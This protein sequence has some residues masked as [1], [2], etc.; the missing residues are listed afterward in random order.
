MP[1]C[2]TV[3]ESM[4]ASRQGIGLHAFQLLA[5]LRSFLKLT[6]RVRNIR[7]ILFLMFHLH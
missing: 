5:G 3:G 6:A 7:P 2:A 1:S 4:N